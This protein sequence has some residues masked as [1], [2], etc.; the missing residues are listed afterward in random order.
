MKTY[1]LL[2]RADLDGVMS[3]VLLKKFGMVDEV[4]FCHPKDVQDGII[5]VSENDIITN[6]PYSENAKFVF[7]HHFYDDV[8]AYNKKSNHAY[9]SPSYIIIISC[10]KRFVKSFFR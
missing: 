4:Q 5:P 6:L 1:K 8:R 9:S 2:T 7:D 3:A 10:R